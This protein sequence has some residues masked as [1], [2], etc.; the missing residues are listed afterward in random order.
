MR[1]LAN[2]G[3]VI[4]IGVFG[5]SCTSDPKSTD[6][7]GAVSRATSTTD[8][9]VIAATPSMSTATIASPV[10]HEQPSSPDLESSTV[11]DGCE[12]S[13]P[14]TTFPGEGLETFHALV[15]GT[16]ELRFVVEAT[17]M[18][19]CPGGII[20]LTVSIHN[21]TDHS[22]TEAPFLVMTDVYPHIVDRSSC[23]H[24]RACGRHGNGRR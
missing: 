17:P 8:G 21:P 12:S 5:A 1:L 18:T 2:A 19:V 6:N 11:E 13:L 10:D 4:V 16:S 15:P 14:S 9:G 7:N 3:M 24:R 23:P 20:H 22:V